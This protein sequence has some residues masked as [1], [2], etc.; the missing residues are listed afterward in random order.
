MA[1]AD[2]AGGA[3][4]AHGVTRAPHGAMSGPLVDVHA[5]FLHA[6]SGRADWEERNR[7]RLEAGA[8]IGITLHIASIL[9]SYGRTSPTY[10]PSP[11]DV[12]AGN[13]ALRAIVRAHPALVKGY[14]AVNPNYT[15]HAVAEIE[16]G[17]AAGMVGVKLAASRRASDPLLDPIAALAA[18]RSVPVLQHAWQH[19]WGEVPH[20][21]ISDAL[22]LAALAAR[23]RGAAFI[24]AHI[25]GGGDWAHSLRALR[26]VPNVF[27]DLSGSGVDR[28]MLE[29]CLECVGAERMVWGCD[30]TMETGWAK[31]RALET[32][33]LAPEALEGIRWKTAA[34][35][36]RLTL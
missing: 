28:G 11:D 20:Q 36:F 13:E 26:E 27:V 23:H 33:G 22:D 2:R 19:R 6:A 17:L 5:H 14:V 32:M 35:L 4:N 9:G 25:G 15:A 16:R 18:E 7:S 10:F 31:L 12:A 34:R 1:E 21:E 29:L 24:L 30:V 3:T 8:R